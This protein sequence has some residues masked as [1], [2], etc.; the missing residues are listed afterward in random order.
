MLQ[1]HR[2]L[3]ESDSRLQ[4]MIKM[5]K[6]EELLSSSTPSTTIR[7]MANKYGRKRNEGHKKILSKDVQSNRT[8]CMERVCLVT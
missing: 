7:A 4:D 8:K 1:K 6:E 5:F 3:H 2:F